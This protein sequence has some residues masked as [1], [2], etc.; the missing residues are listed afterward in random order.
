MGTQL[1]SPKWGR[2]PSPQFSAHVY[3]GQTAGW[4]KIA[5]GMEVGP[6]SDHIVLDGDRAHLPQIFGP[7]LLWP[8][9]WMHQDATWYGGRPHAHPRRLCVRSGPSP[10]SPKGAQPPVFGLCLLWPKGWMYENATWSEVDLGHIVL[11][12]D[13]APPQ[14]GHSSP[15]PSFRPMSIVATVAHLT[16]W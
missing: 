12:R 2:S 4:I 7:F 6:G 8:N 5:L 16:Y 3:C 9:G 11:H 1:P 10:H 13:P 14:K 15:T